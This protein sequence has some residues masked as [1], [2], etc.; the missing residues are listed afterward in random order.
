MR[1]RI[2][3][4]QPTKRN[5]SGYS[6]IE[7]LIVVLVVAALAGSGIVFYQRHNPISAK[8]SAATITIQTTTPSKSTTTTH[9]A[10]TTSQYFTITE[11]G[12]KA[13]PD[14]T[15]TLRYKIWPSAP[16]IADFTSDQ[17][18]S[19][20]SNPGCGIGLTP[21]DTTDTTGNHG[22]GVIMR[23]LPTDVV[24]DL[25]GDNSSSGTAEQFASNP[26]Y[27]AFKSDIVKAGSYYYVYYHEQGPCADT[28]F[29]QE[30]TES[31]VKNLL[32]SF[33]PE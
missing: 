4:H 13:K 3:L 29:V 14:D 27:A 7:V 17:L 24:H 25:V 28:G 15:F 5:Q 32:Q 23:L 11:W 6:I 16:N 12:I 26:Q 9:P 30:N 18:T 19:A 10:Q 31:A 22:G 20:S 8:N 1:L 33:Q 2:H 21:G